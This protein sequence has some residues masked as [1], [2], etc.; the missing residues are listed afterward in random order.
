VKPG[1]ARWLRGLEDQGWFHATSY[2]PNQGVRVRRGSML[3]LLV[4]GACGIYTMIMHKALG[5]DLL[6]TGNN[7]ELTVP[8]T[9]DEA[10]IFRVIPLIYQV[11]YTLPL[12]LCL[13]LIWFAWRVVNW[14]A[15]ADFLIAT[16]AEMNKFSC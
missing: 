12:A 16:E 10:G 5:T 13:L 3:A 8:F 11:H 4:L 14:P 6:G 7:L 2:K 1:C 9:L 15:S